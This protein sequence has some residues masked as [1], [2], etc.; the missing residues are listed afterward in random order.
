M[1][2]E[3]RRKGIKRRRLRRRLRQGTLE[4]KPVGV[5][6]FEPLQVFFKKKALSR[7]RA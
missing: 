4:K 7:E 6:H 5:Q 2:F 1:S 3:M